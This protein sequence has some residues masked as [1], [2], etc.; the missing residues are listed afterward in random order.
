MSR[1]MCDAGGEAEDCEDMLPLPLDIT[2]GC[3]ATLL[4][5][6]AS[7]GRR[8]LRANGRVTADMGGGRSSSSDERMMRRWTR[9]AGARGGDEDDDDGNVVVED[10]G[11]ETAIG[12]CSMDR[13]VGSA[14]VAAAA[15][16]AGS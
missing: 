14:A 3:G 1:G 10:G 2:S 8:E 9:G 6:L 4:P 12:G 13:G 11:M 15:A 16:T 5:P 7:T